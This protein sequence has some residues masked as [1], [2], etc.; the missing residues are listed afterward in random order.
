MTNESGRET[1]SAAAL[2]S[3]PSTGT[4]MND[5]PHPARSFHMA[6]SFQSLWEI[7]YIFVTS[8]SELGSV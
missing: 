2:P 4:R 1:L 6:T 5:F 7:S 3:F 8:A